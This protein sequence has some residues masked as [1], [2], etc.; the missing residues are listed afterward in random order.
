[1]CED[2]EAGKKLAHVADAAVYLPE[3]KDPA[4]MSDEWFDELVKKYT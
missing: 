3:G 1:L 2:D 4:Q